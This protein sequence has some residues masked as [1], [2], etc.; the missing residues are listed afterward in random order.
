MGGK[1]IGLLMRLLFGD[2]QLGQ[3]VKKRLFHK[4][5]MAK[6]RTIIVVAGP[7]DAHKLKGAIEVLNGKAHARAFPNKK[8]KMDGF[9]PI[10]FREGGADQ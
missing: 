6:N 5:D 8:R 10:R 3:I 1:M 9:V 2:M 7:L 4:S